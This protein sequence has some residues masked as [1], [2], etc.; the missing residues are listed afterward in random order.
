MSPHASSLPEQWVEQIFA[1]LRATYGSAVDHQ[2][3]P[4]PGADATA[5]ALNLRAHWARE[6][7][8]YANRGDAIAYA[9]SHLP[10]R[11]PNL[12]EFRN[13]CNRAPKPEQQALPQAKA[14][15]ARRDAVLAGLKRPSVRS[16]LQWAYDLKAREEAGERLPLHHR[17][18]WR[19]A[20]RLNLHRE[21]A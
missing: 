20:L 8:A 16:P 5:H 6:L 15:P 12:V 21:A 18:Q 11:P 19:A 7:G 10:E 2:W 14:D 9:L 4:S 1:R 3:A 13:L 17:E